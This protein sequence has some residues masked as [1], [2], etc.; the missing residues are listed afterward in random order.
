MLA[1]RSIV[2][3]PHPRLR[4]ELLGLS[5]EVG[6]TGIRVT[7]RGPTHNDHAVVCRMIAASLVRDLGRQPLFFV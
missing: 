4:E 2:F 5:V 1:A 7:D 3:P 6:A